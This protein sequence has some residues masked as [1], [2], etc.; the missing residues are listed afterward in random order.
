[1]GGWPFA[2][3]NFDQVRGYRERALAGKPRHP[4]PNAPQRLRDRPLGGGDLRNSRV[5][6]IGDLLVEGAG[7]GKDLEFEVG[8]RIESEVGADP[9][10]LFR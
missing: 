2:S 3:A 10:R 7:W 1:M 8:V 9:G 4:G 6:G 5:E